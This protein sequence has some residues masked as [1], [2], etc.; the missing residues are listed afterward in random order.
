[1]PCCCTDEHCCCNV[2][3]AINHIHTIDDVSL[4]GM[5]SLQNV[6]PIVG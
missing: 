1:M 2:R 5:T 3:V 6:T 4:A